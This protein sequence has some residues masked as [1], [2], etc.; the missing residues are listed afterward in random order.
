MKQVIQSYKT[1]EVAEAKA[2]IVIEPDADQLA[3]TLI[4]LLDSPKLRAEMGANGRRLVLEKFT[5][6][7]VANQ[8]IQLY[9]DVLENWRKRD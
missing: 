5:W 1:G 7:K 8:M 2:G 6:D 3:S 9:Q 4:R